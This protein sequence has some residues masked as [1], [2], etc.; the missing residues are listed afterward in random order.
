MKS[1]NFLSFL[2]FH[3][4]PI[5]TI[6]GTCPA[7]KNNNMRYHIKHRSRTILC[8]AFFAIIFG[9]NYKKSHTGSQDRFIYDYDIIFFGR[10]SAV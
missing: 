1:R 10:T 6:S 2:I 5:D 7:K 4:R 8:V 3:F 9:Q